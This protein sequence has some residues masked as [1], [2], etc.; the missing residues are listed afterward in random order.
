MLRILRGAKADHEL[1]RAV[2]LS[3]CPDCTELSGPEKPRAVAAPSR[4][5]FNYEAILD[6]FTVHDA[7]G[8]P[9]LILSIV[10]DGTVLH[11]VA[12]LRQG[13]VQPSSMLC[14]KWFSSKCA[15]WDGWLT[16]VSSDRGR[17]NR[18]HLRRASKPMAASCGRLD[19]RTPRGSVAESAP[20]VFG[21][22]HSV[23]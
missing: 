15:S 23:G 12:V 16:N 17:H 18:A 10:C 8:V 4:Y 20:K 2:R 14:F 11:V 21:K 7:N 3:K 6:V 13:T 22:R 19:L 5:M 1:I 9:Y